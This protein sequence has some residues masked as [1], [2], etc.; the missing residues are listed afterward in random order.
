MD[1]EILLSPPATP[2]LTFINVN[3][4]QQQIVNS[5]KSI[6]SLI[7]VNGVITPNPS[8]S[9]DDHEFIPQ[10]KHN[11][12]SHFQPSLTPPPESSSNPDE[13][14]TTQ[15]TRASVIM[16][17]SRNG[18]CSVPKDVDQ[19]MDVDK[20]EDDAINVFRAVKFKMGRLSTNKLDNEL[21]TTKSEEADH[22]TNDFLVYND[23]SSKT[24]NSL[25]LRTQSESQHVDRKTSYLP[26]VPKNVYCLT[27]ESSNI[28]PAQLVLIKSTNAPFPTFSQPAKPVQE[29]RRVYECHYQNCG[30][31]YFKSSHLK[32][33]QRVHTGER[34]F[35]C[36]WESC[37]RR[38]SRSDELSRHKRTHTGEKK[39]VCP[40]CLKKFMRSDHLSKHVKRHGKEKNAPQQTGGSPIIQLRPIIPAPVQ[41]HICNDAIALQV[42]PSSV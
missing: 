19:S 40:V 10:N 28:I 8:D 42:H 9:E 11:F 24:L 17:V 7:P 39:F 18:V 4:E 34:P 22:A 27:T 21:N 14:S 29:R 33:H 36:K 31:N 23:M 41:V 3:G 5:Q 15:P 26:I 12:L 20:C 25:E 30:K 2:P 32:A 38:F 35:V 1:F 6:E 16:H 37:D 13:T